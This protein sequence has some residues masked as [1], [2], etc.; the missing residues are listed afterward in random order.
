L[1]AVEEVFDPYRKWLGIPPEEQPP[2]HYRL[3]GIALYETDPDVISNAA[4][5]QM[6]HVRTFQTGKRAPLSQALLNELSAARICLLNPDSKQQ[7]DDKLLAWHSQL[8]RA[9]AVPAE[10]FPQPGVPTA[11]PLGTVPTAVPIADPDETATH[12][13]LD[14]ALPTIR[15]GKKKPKF[16][17]PGAG[18]QQPATAR[19]VSARPV[20]VQPVPVRTAAVKSAAPIAVAASAAKSAESDAPIPVAMRGTSARV[21]RRSSSSN[22][23]TGIIGVGMA[24]AL[25][26]V[27][28]MLFSG[29]GDDSS[30]SETNRERPGAKEK[31]KQPRPSVPAPNAVPAV[32]PATNEQPPIPPK[33]IEKKPEK[34][35][36]SPKE[37][38]ANDA[39]VTDDPPEKNPDEPSDPKTPDVEDEPSRAATVKR[40]APPAAEAIGKAYRILRKELEPQ[41]RAAVE[42]EE[43]HEL[44]AQIVERA[45]AEK[46]PA[47]QYALYMIAHNLGVQLASVDTA[48]DVIDLLA[49]KYDVDAFEM[50]RTAIDQISQFVTLGVEDYDHLLRLLQRLS[51]EAMSAEKSDAAMALSRLAKG[52]S[53]KVRS[54]KTIKEFPALEDLLADV[55]RLATEAAEF[56]REVNAFDRNAKI[57]EKEPNDAAANLSVGRYWLL[58]K[59]DWLKALPHLAK[60]A[61]PTVKDP[62]I[63]DLAGPKTLPEQVALADTWASLAPRKGGLHAPRLLERAR[64]W[65]AQAAKTAAEAEKQAIEAKIAQ[66]DVQL[67]AVIPPAASARDEKPTDEKATDENEPTDGAFPDAPDEKAPDP[68]KPD[69]AKPAP[70]SPADDDA[71]AFPD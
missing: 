29:G 41:L 22:A 49:A 38:P 63:L 61:D 21:V 26:I 50:K 64:H 32:N 31:P 24:A 28:V 62:A 35:D 40:P 47:N 20:A 18:E 6:A 34:T 17:F 9:V 68:A 33:P 15:T 65:Y 30:T 4:D 25:I 48:C 57:L 23:I 44:V 12:D 11:I 59:G 37:Q 56:D 39:V 46:E 45:A 53:L 54:P 70:A 1:T 19:P 67:K 55:D 5:R 43:R 7:Y 51:R 60:S 52:T 10:H 66:V 3:L 14:V 16:D 71:P 8:T 69:P 36:D 27:V 58:V 42:P 2:N 13:T